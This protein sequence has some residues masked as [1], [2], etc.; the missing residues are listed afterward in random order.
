MQNADHLVAGI[1]G[2]V[3]KEMVA[4]VPQVTPDEK[5]SEPCARGRCGQ[6]APIASAF[7]IAV[8]GLF[9]GDV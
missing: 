4:Q 6:S 9:L 5:M 7:C 8:T 2:Q 3:V 1:R